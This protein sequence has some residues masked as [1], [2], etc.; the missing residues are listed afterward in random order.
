MKRVR[1]YLTL[2]DRECIERMWRDG[3]TQKEIA[4]KLGIHF[5]TVYEELRRGENGLSYTDHR[6]AYDA[7]LAQQVFLDNLKKR[8]RHKRGMN[9][10]KEVGAKT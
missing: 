9:G 6:R 4:Q 7:D 3:A 8:G 1:G 2:S 5:T 10:C